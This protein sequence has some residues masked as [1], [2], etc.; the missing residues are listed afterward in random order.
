MARIGGS[1]QHPVGNGLL[2]EQ[3]PPERRGFAISAHIAGGNVG[4]VV[5]AVD[6]RAAHRRSSAGAARRSSSGSPA[7]AIA[8]A[9]LLLIREHGTDRAAA[10][11]RRLRRATRF[12]R[13]RRATATCAGCILTSVLGGGGR[14][15]GVVNL[16]ALIYL[17]RVLGVDEATAGLMYGALIVF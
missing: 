3:F 16:F 4:T 10:R 13:D 9:I 8:I 17:T 11:R 15:L 2:A 7:I 1:P 6:R 12:G 14:G 5:V